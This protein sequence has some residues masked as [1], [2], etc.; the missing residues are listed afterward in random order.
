M[1]LSADGQRLVVGNSGA[2]APIPFAADVV[3]R[4]GESTRA[5]SVTVH[6]VTRQP[7]L[8]QLVYE[9]E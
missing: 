6:R 3:S 7:V 2:S 1:R 9:I 5:T 8:S 4:R